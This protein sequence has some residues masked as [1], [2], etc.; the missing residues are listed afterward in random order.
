[1]KLH[2]EW[3][4]L[5]IFDCFEVLFM[6]LNEDLKLLSYDTQT[7]KYSIEDCELIGL[8]KFWYIYFNVSDPK[9]VKRTKDFLWKL[10][11]FEAK[12]EVKRSFLKSYIDKILK[13][14]ENSE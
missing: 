14:S 7:S 10:S 13:L 5:K 2:G 12:G 8:D 11:T 9:V 6:R 3:F 4:S 1:M